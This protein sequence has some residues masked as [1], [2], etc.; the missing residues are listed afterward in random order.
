MPYCILCKSYHIK[1]ALFNGRSGIGCPTCQ[2]AERHRLFGYYYDKYI[3]NKQNLSILHFAPEN[4]LYNLLKSSSSKYVCGDFDPSNYPNKN[5]MQLDA[6]NLNDVFADNT[7]DMIIAS[8]ILE[9]IPADIK[10]L[11][12]L[13]RILKKGAKLIIMIPQSFDSN[14][15]DEDLTITDPIARTQRYG[16]Y[17]HVRKYGL[18]FTSRV[19][20]V[21]FFIKAFIPYQRINDVSKMITDSVIVVATDDIMMKD[22]VFSQ[23]D[24]LYECTKP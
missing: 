22:N 15:T 10:A 11:N 14:A 5:C 8:H 1:F 3:S 20:A 18:D 7:F 9:H 16:Q 23:W 24:I 13:Y 4:C 21:G 12:E 6:T 2:S 19:K 17:D